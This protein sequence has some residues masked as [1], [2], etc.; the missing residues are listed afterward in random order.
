MVDSKNYNNVIQALYPMLLDMYKDC[1]KKPKSISA[2]D[3]RD[4]LV[5]VGEKLCEIQI[6][7]MKAGSRVC[8]T[9]CI[10]EYPN[11]KK[12]RNRGVEV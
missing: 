7:M 1:C 2:V 5:Y 10:D 9:A 8:I 12:F 3:K 4:A 11:P 6:S